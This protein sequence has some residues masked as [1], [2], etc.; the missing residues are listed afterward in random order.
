MRVSI[1]GY[2]LEVQLSCM[3]DGRCRLLEHMRQMLG[4]NI[5]Q[6][7]G[8]HVSKEYSLENARYTLFVKLQYLLIGSLDGFGCPVVSVVRDEWRE[9]GFVECDHCTSLFIVSIWGAKPLEGMQASEGFRNDREYPR[10]HD[11]L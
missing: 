4:L 1:V 2:G 8:G 6:R 9:D 11:S 5:S 3:L 7:D 10:R